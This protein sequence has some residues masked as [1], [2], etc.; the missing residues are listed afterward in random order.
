MAYVHLATGDTDMSEFEILANL[1][2]A[3]VCSGAIIYMWQ[4]IRISGADRW[5]DPDAVAHL[6]ET[7]PYH[8]LDNV[9]PRK[10]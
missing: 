10:R 8:R 1:T 2:V 5:Q 7:A 4:V 3:A 6:I 9:Y